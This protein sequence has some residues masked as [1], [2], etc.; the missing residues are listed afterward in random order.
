MITRHDATDQTATALAYHHLSRAAAHLTNIA[1][2]VAWP[3]D[4]LD[5]YEGRDGLRA[6]D[7]DAAT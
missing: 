4:Q 1:T 5:H 7:V 3:L 6:R 2:A